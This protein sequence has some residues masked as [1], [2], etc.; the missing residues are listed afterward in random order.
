L[1][2]TVAVFRLMSGRRSAGVAA[3]DAIAGPQTLKSTNPV[4]A[5]GLAPP[6]TLTVALP[7]PLVAAQRDPAVAE[8]DVG[9]EGA[10]GPARA[11]FTFLGVIDSL[12]WTITFVR[13]DAWAGGHALD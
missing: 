7:H 13:T 3:R 1:P 2:L 5:G 8:G 6:V 10:V 11:R 12:M 4:G 9:V